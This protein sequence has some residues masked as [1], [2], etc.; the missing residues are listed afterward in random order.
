MQMCQPFES[1]LCKHLNANVK[2]TGNQSHCP[3]FWRDWRVLNKISKN[4]EHFEKK[5]KKEEEE[6]NKF[7]SKP[8]TFCKP[9][10]ANVKPKVSDS[11]HPTLPTF[12][13]SDLKKMLA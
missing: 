4:N 10:N 3:C 2:P 6:E 5:K 8:S 11:L 7:A 9:L 12:C 13:Q 1:Q